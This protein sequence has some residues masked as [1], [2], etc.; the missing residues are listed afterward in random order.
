MPL[1]GLHPVTSRASRL[2]GRV[3]AWSLALLAIA[4]VQVGSAGGTG[5]FGILGPAGT[6][7]LRLCAGA[8]IFV[9]LRRP[10]L[11]GRPRRE[12]LGAIALG[13]VTGGMTISFNLALARIPLGTTVAIEFLGPLTVAVMGT[14]SLR[15]LVWPVLALGGVLA[16]TEPWVG[17]VDPV[18]I[19]FAAGG[20][21]GWALY[22]L[23]TAAVGDA[24]EGL[25]GLS[26]T[27]PIAAVVTA[28]IGL[29]QAVGHIGVGE[30]AAAFGLAILLPVLP[31]SLE[32]M[33]L[34]R[35]PIATFGTLMA[36]EPAMALLAGVVLLAQIPTPLQAAGI[37]LVVIAGMGATRGGERRGPRIDNPVPLIE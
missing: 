15:R 22:I 10:R 2:A 12:L 5:L 7:W 16:L 33:A 1:P 24:F 23:L 31:Y 11:R 29:P 25:E 37:A 28:A 35:L 18:G 36:L 9:V 20:G 34:R 21:T 6:A 14:R 8:V 19:L 4:S 26:V 3:P 30:I 17:A 27:I 32:L 13:A